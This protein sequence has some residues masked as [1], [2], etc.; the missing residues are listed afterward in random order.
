MKF[1]TAVD[2]DATPAT[3]WRILTDVESWPKWSASM[4]SVERL[5]QGELAVGSTARVTQPKLK[6]AVYTVTECE[7][8]KS[9]VWEMQ[10]TGVKVRATHFVEDKGD[11]HARMVLGI[12]Q[13]G[14]LSGLI[15]MFYGK[16]TRQYVTM[17]AEGLK[18]AAETETAEKAE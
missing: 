18:R 10:G 2:I 5:Q 14:A 15:A 17:E 3:V 4:T 7:P 11:G 16:L 9:F 1:Q 12:E 6:V 8:G 13:S